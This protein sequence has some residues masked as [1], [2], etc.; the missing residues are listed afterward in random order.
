MNRLQHH[1]VLRSVAVTLGC[2]ILTA[3]AGIAIAACQGGCSGSL[4]IPTTPRERA[5]AVVLVLASGVEEADHRC[6]D[7]GRDAND[8]ALLDRCTVAYK[9]A[10]S[11]LLVAAGAVDTYDQSSTDTAC[12]TATGLAAAVELAG[13]ITSTGAKL[14]AALTDGLELAKQFAP[15]CAPK[16]GAS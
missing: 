13:I 14:P 11:A 10:R 1:P 9:D 16:D 15:A 3:H 8:L 6:A 2:A 4:P 5:R 7:I 12:A